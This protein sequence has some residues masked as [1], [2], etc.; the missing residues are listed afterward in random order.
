LDYLTY[1]LLVPLFVKYVS[2]A[3]YEDMNRRI[4]QILVTIGFLFSLMVLVTPSWFFSKTL[5]IYQIFT[6]LACGYGLFCIVKA[7]R[8]KRE[9]SLIL[10]AGL[11]VLF[12][13]A[14]ND[15]LYTQEII[16]TG[17]LVG[18]GFFVLVICMSVLIN[19]RNIKAYYRVEELTQTLEERV[20]E[21]TKELEVAFEEIKNLALVDVLTGL[22]NRRKMMPLLEF[23]QKR[24][25][26]EKIQF[27]IALIDIDNFKKVNDT[28]GHNCGDLVLKRVALALSENIRKQDQ[29]CRWGGEEFLILFPATGIDGALIVAE[30]IRKA[31]ESLVI[32][33]ENM[34]L[35]ITIT[36]GFSISNPEIS[37]DDLIKQAD[38]ALYKGK[39]SGKNRVISSC[40]QT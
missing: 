37:I 7:L 3:F 11:C 38:D 36:I 16:Q 31:V 5:W 26:R 13:A 19:F 29:A 34:E 27:A 15:V 2:S 25:Q 23:E 28:Y 33:H 20:K 35:K 6:L 10:V 9:G 30:N 24:I 21:R 8:N 40:D 18:Y 14:V 1:Y 17:V 22:A 32:E 4:R 39:N 12:T